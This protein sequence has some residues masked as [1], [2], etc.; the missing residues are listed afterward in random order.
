MDLPDVE[1]IIQWKATCDLCTLWQR[2]GRAVRDL[3]LQGKALFLVESKYFDAAKKA[4]ADAAEERKRKAVERATG[5]APPQKRARTAKGPQDTSKNLMNA[6]VTEA[7]LTR[8]EGAVVMDEET[9]HYEARDARDDD[10]AENVPSATDSEA[11]PSPPR[12]SVDIMSSI[13]PSAQDVENSSRQLFEAERRMEYEKVPQIERKRGTRKVE[14]IEPAL[15]D[16]IN[17]KDCHVQCS[18]W[19]TVVYRSEEHTSELQSQ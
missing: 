12:V 7:V 4:K 9:R 19:P 10:E 11:V 17:G 15:D 2:F 18:R 5:R 6:A 13:S 1:L 3:R 14:E 8:A 16:M